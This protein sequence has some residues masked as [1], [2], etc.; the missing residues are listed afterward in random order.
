MVVDT[1]PIDLAIL[2]QEDHHRQ[3]ST[4]SSTEDDNDMAMTRPHMGDLEGGVRTEC[5]R[6]NHSEVEEDTPDIPPPPHP[7]IE[8]LLKPEEDKGKGKDT[9]DDNPLDTAT[10]TPMMIA[11]VVVKEEENGVQHTQSLL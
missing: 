7:M 11:A 5:R 2:Q 1:D 3:D 10:T 6:E 8:E 9:Q 4:A